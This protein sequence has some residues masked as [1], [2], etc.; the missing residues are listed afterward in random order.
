MATDQYTPK[1]R[2]EKKPTQVLPVPRLSYYH[3]D[4]P[5]AHCDPDLWQSQDD[6]RDVCKPL[7]H[8]QSATLGELWPD[9]AA[10]FILD[11]AAQQPR[12]HGVGH[13]RR[14]GRLQPGGLCICA[15]AIQR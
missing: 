13:G 1:Q 14:V 6:W 7:H 15:D 10:V 2:F 4:H 5:G 9:L 11:L 8:P 3:G 12:R